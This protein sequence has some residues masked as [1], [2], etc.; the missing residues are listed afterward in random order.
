M[1]I[2]LPQCI[3]TSSFQ[4]QSYARLIWHHCHCLYAPCTGRLTEHCISILFLTLWSQQT[5][6]MPSTPRTWTAKS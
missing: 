3:T 4:R 2:N 6:A 5:K 1:K